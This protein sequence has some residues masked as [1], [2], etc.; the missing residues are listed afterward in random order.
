MP[1][2]N[3]LLTDQEFVELYNSKGPV[4]IQKTIGLARRNVQQRRQRLERRLG[5]EIRSP[6]GDGYGR[7][8]GPRAKWRLDLDFQD[9]V[10][11]VAS[12]CHYWPGNVPFMHKVLVR[13]IKELKPKILVLNGDVMDFPKISRHPSIGWENRPNVQEEIEF[14]QEM[15]HEIAMALPRGAQKIWTMG[16]H[17]ERFSNR[18]ANQNQEYAKVNGFQLKDH[19]PVWEPAYQVYINPAAGHEAILIHHRFKGGEHAISNNLKWTGCHSVT[20]HLHKAEI[21]ALTYYNDRTIWGV[22]TGCVAE[23]NSSAFEYTRGAPTGWREGF[24]ILT[25]RGC[26]LLHPELVLRWDEKHIQFRGE[27]IKP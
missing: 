16:N 19:F 21:R 20:G 1:R 23:P 10:I 27:I 9:G 6:N 18:L 24:A 8:P 26:R 3:P 2:G 12:D 5:V 13:H 11:I 14:A 15:T 4:Y 25:L 17:D 7:I 22:D